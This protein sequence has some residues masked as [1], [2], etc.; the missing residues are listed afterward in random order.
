MCP[1]MI[2]TCPPRTPPET[3]PGSSLPPMI[4]PR[5]ALLVLLASASALQAQAVEPGVDT[6]VAPGDDFFAFANGRWLETTAIP[7]G[8]ERWGAR[9]EID[10]LTQR[11]IA[12]LL[13]DARSAPPGSVARAVADFR[14]AW[15]DEAAIEVRGRAAL[16]PILDTIARIAD[17]TALARLLGRWIGSDVDPLNWGIY[18][19][20][21]LFG[22]A[23]EPGIGG[24]K[25]CPAFLLQGGLGLPDRDDYLSVEPRLVGLRARYREYA[26]RLLAVAGFDASA[27]RAERVVALETAIA[28]SHVTRA[29]SAN[30]HNADHRWGRTD[31]AREAPG[32][33]WSAF[34]DAAGLAREDTIFVWQPGAV[35][36]IA[37]LVAAAPLETWKDYLRVRVL[38]ETADVLPRAFADERLAMQRALSGARPSPRAERALAATAAAMSDAIG[39][40]YAGRHFSPVQKARVQRIAAGVTAAFVRHVETASWMSPETRA[41][42]LAKLRSLYVG[43]GYPDRWDDSADVRIDPRD[44]LG[45]QRRV[46]ERHHARA[47]AQLGEPVDRTRWWIAPQTVGAILAFQQNAYDFSAALLQAPKF[48]STASDAAV[49]GSI[50]AIIGHDVSHYVDVL[51]AEYDTAFA[52]RRWWTAQD[53]SRFEAVAEPLVRQFSAYRPFADLAVNGR[54]TRT[55]NVADL[56]GLTAAF[57]AYRLSL[58]MRDSTAVRHLDREFFIAWARAWRVK[59]RDDA[60]RTQLAS[61]DHAPEMYRVNTVR[62]LDAWYVAFDVRPGQRLYLAP[63]ERV[64]VW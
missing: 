57:E 54:L 16:A 39:R 23:V 12:T 35:T 17:Q 25:T 6:S 40:M 14:A 44:A 5:A 13:D 50:G 64:R 43:I 27:E 56:A 61:N 37:A 8:R 41:L 21:R 26:A 4:D 59:I 9:N 42:A 30:D 3:G 34:L 49:Y 15:L 11:Q 10:A 62:N 38:D 31:F 58:A 52:E 2:Q 46:Q 45:N 55:E 32:M 48:D 24:E 7:E 1:E 63:A 33:D 28:R 60:L 19:S 53:S 20:S 36:G 51:G 22:L 29:A 47:L 18:Q